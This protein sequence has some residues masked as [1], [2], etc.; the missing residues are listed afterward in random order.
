MGIVGAGP[1]G[2]VAALR[3]ADLGVPSIILEASPEL[4]RQGSKACL[5][6]GDALEILDRSG[7]AEIIN[8]EG[9]TWTVART[10]VRNEVIRT[11]VYPRRAGFGPFVN[12]SQYRIE[13][14]LAAEVARRPLCDL[15]WGHQVTG[16]SQDNDGVSVT[17]ATPGGERGMRFRYLVACDGVRSA[18]RGMVGVEWTGYTHKDCFLITDIRPGCRSTRGGT[19]ITTRPSTPAG[20]SSSTPSP[21][22]SGGST[23]SSLLMPISTRSGP[24]ESST[25]G[26]APSSA[27]CPTRSTG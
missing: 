21:T 15:R 25:P 14:V 27:T 9:V 3:L 4:L 22:T 10:Y 5:I 23:G 17:V 8:A 2:L 12:I 16:V 6:H 19:S 20:S 7:C 24:A 26:S 11:D 1:V 18:L 13:Q